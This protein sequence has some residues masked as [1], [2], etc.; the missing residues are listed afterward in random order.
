MKIMLR[1]GS[2]GQV[3]HWLMRGLLDGGATSASQV[4]APPGQDFDARIIRLCQQYDQLPLLVELATTDED[5]AIETAIRLRKLGS[6]LVVQLPIVGPDGGD[7]LHIVHRLTS[8]RVPVGVTLCMSV[9]QVILAWKAGASLVSMMWNDILDD[10]G[11]PIRVAAGCTQW[12]AN[13]VNGQQLIV[14]SVRSVGDVYDVLRSGAD[15]MILDDQVLRRMS[16][17]RAAAV[18]AQ[19]FGER[20]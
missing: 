17:Q 15:A 9:G 6:N 8:E 3:Q 19:A 2:S 1:A 7:L 20:L 4:L 16:Q 13:R 11:D 5:D 12:A 18:A 14:D 10:G